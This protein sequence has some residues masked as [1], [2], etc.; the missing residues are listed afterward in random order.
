MK[1]VALEN[2]EHLDMLLG[3]NAVE[4]CYLAIREMIED[5]RDL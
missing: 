5:T 2:Y 1:T 4:D 3:V